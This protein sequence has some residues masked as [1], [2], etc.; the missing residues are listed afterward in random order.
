MA[1]VYALYM[2]E[3][4]IALMSMFGARHHCYPHII[5]EETEAQRGSITCPS[6]IAAG[7]LFIYLA[8]PGLRC[9]MWDPVHRPGNKP[10]PPCLGSMES[11]LLDHQGSPPYASC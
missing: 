6:P 5:D 8:A 1:N 9:G 2:Y 7:V 4:N 11:W 10:G 3:L